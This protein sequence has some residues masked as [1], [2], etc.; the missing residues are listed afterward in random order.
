MLGEMGDELTGW[1]FAKHD[2]SR[3]MFGQNIMR[4]GFG[5]PGNDRQS[6]HGHPP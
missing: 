4:F 1:P 5:D 2:L 6:F 3:K